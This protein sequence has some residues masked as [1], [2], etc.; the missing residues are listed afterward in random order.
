M[1]IDI[2]FLAW[3]RL[4]FTRFS[5]SALL[6]NTDWAKV[7]SLWLYDDGSEDGTLE[8]LKTIKAPCKT[9]LV[10]TTLRS[11][12][13]IMNDF[14]NRVKPE[15][16]A[17]IDNDTV[18]PPL[19]L[20]ECTD[21]MEANPQIDILGIEPMHEV[22]KGPV[23]RSCVGTKWVGGIG[24]MRGHVFNTLPVPNGRFGFT[25]WQKW[26]PKV[27]K[28]WIQPALPVILL[29]RVPV[30]PWCSLSDEYIRK[31]W[32]RPWEPY[33]KADRALWTPP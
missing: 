13:A 16:F 12:V 23:P 24:L 19:W 15:V 20:N 5:I 3:N 30:E 9:A 7:R 33:T 26:T 32:Q 29:N 25:S 31:G 28:A 18:V 1:H 10:Q 21:L 8:L 4:R 14:I 6:H 11:P 22:A 27:A 17:K 2:L